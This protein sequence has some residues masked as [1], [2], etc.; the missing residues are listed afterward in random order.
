DVR[1]VVGIQMGMAQ[2]AGTKHYFQP[3]IGFEQMD[4]VEYRLSHQINIGSAIRSVG[5]IDIRILYVPAGV[6]LNKPARLRVQQHQ[7][8]GESPWP[9]IDT[10]GRARPVRIQEDLNVR[11]VAGKIVVKNR[12][13][14]VLRVRSTSAAE[15]M[16]EIGGIG[17]V[18]AVVVRL[19]R[20]RAAVGV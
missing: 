17:R 6:E 16:I 8:S 14:L 5:Q 20:Y 13:R 4:H 10:A 19:I 7:K 15:I 2:T 3:R 11:N 12:Y 18:I 9:V 1:Y